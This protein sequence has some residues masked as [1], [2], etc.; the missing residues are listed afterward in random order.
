MTLKQ[1]TDAIRIVRVEKDGTRRVV[2]CS[3]S[4]ADADRSCIMLTR[5]FYNYNSGREYVTERNPKYRFDDAL[6]VV[7]LA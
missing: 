1:Y 6:R 2:G 3:H 5:E 7:G 4:Q